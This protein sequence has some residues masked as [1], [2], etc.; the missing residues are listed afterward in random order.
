MNPLLEKNLP[1][2][3]ILCAR[4][5]VESLHAFGS[6]IRDDFRPDSDIDLIVDFKPRPNGNA[7]RRYFD[8]KEQLE[9]LLGQPVDLITARSLTNPFFKQEVD[10]TKHPVYAA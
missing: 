4:H 6:I 9:E 7:F 1:A 10:Q 5:D 8:L 2:I 3:R